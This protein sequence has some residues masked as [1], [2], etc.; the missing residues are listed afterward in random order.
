MLKQ[1]TAGSLLSLR[2]WPEAA[3]VWDIPEMPM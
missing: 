2:F 1:P 3:A